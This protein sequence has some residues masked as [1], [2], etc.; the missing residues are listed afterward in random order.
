MNAPTSLAALIAKLEAASGPSADLDDAIADAVLT[1][2]PPVYLAGEAPAGDTQPIKLWRDPDG[3]VGTCRRYTTSLDAAM[4][5]V[6]PED[7][8][9]SYTILNDSGCWFVSF[10]TLVEGGAYVETRTEA[11]RLDAALL[12]CEK[13]FRHIAALRAR[14]SEQG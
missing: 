12:F 3:S 6:R 1:V 10:D 8:I 14:V 5:L 2:A 7:D 4:S 9:D 13:Y 11:G